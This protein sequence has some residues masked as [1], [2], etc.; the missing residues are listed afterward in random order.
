M[1]HTIVTEPAVKRLDQ[2]GRCCGRKPLVYKRPYHRLFCC[3]CSAAFMPNGVQ[4]AN[5]AFVAKGDGFV[6]SELCVKAA[7]ATAAWGN[8][9]AIGPSSCD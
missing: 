9:P 2:H 7:E 8:K 5:W 1:H 3:R 4:V 6:S